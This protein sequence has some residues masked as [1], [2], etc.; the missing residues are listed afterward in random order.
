VE[1]A[2]RFLGFWRAGRATGASGRKTLHQTDE[3]RYRV[4]GLYED[5]RL[6]I[7]DVFWRDPTGPAAACDVCGQLIGVDEGAVVSRRPR[8]DRWLHEACYVLVLEERMRRLPP[9]D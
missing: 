4:W 2:F 6:S 8:L 1:L 7:Y 9:A 3:V 5:Q